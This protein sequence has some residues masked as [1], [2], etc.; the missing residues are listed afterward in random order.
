MDRPLAAIG[1]RGCHGRASGARRSWRATDARGRRLDLAGGDRHRSD[2]AGAA[3][4]AA[5]SDAVRVEPPDTWSGLVDGRGLSPDHAVHRDIVLQA[6]A[7]VLRARAPSGASDRRRLPR[8]V[9][10][11]ASRPV[12]G[13]GARTRRGTDIPAPALVRALGRRAPPT[14][15]ER[16]RPGLPPLYDGGARR[17]AGGGAMSGNAEAVIL[18]A[19]Q[20]TMVVAAAPLLNGFIKKIKARFQLRHGPPLLQGYFDLAKWLSRS[21]QVADSTSFVHSFA[22]A[23]IVAATI[24]ALLFAPVFSEHTPLTA[25]GDLIVVVGLLALTRA[26]LTLGGMDS[27]SAFGQM[28]SSRELAVGAIVEPVLLLS[29]TALAL[30]PQSTR[31]G[32][33]VAFG[34]GHPASFFSLGWALAAAAFAVVLVAETG[35]IPVDNPDTHL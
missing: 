17:A 6:T 18:G 23:G 5:G 15:S 8:R 22:P 29:L 32:E 31:L 11:A 16:Q 33:I 25:S 2:R 26:L 3:A 30:Q 1:A 27:G 13:S 4:M 12:L 19:V 34:D 7:P 24:A 21:E 14:D 10:V 35:R 9:A 20:V 28:G